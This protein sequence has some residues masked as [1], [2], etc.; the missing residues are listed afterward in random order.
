[1]SRP[2][3]ILIAIVVVIAGALVLLSSRAKERPTTRVEK[4]VSLANLQ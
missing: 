3:L 2:I 4:V 1:M